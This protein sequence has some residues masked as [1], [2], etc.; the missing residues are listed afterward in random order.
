VIRLRCASVGL[1]VIGVLSI[2]AGAGAENSAGI[3]KTSKRFSVRDDIELTRF[4]W[5][6]VRASP[7]YQ[8]FAIVSERG[9]LDRN[10][11]EDSLWVFRADDILTRLRSAEQTGG[12][13]VSQTPLVKITAKHSPVIFDLD[14][15]DDSTLAFRTQTADHKFQL[16]KADVKT[17]TVEAISG[18]DQ[19]VGEFGG[20]DVRNGNAIYSVL[21][22]LIQREVEDAKKPRP[23]K[24]IEGS[25]ESVLNLP[26]SDGS[27]SHEG[28]FDWRE[29][30]AVIRG[31]RFRVDTSAFQNPLHISPGV[32]TSRM[33]LSPDGRFVVVPLPVL[34]VP[35]LWSSYAINK[36][37][38]F[39]GQFRSGSQN[40]EV[41]ETDFLAQ[42]FVM[43]DLIKGTARPLLD[44][45]IGS[46]GGYHRPRPVA[47][48]SADGQRIALVNT[49]L[50]I[51]S[52]ESPLVPCIA[53][54][55]VPTGKVGCVETLAAE[56]KDGY[57]ERFTSV[58]DLHF[59]PNDGRRLI[60]SYTDE[61]NA[62]AGK[63]TYQEEQDITWTRVENGMAS[64]SSVEVIVQESLNDPPRLVAVDRKSGRSTLV[65]DPNARVREMDLGEASEYRWADESGRSWVG[66]LVTPPDYVAGR[67]HPLVI[68]THGF[69]RNKFMGG[70]NLGW[71][72]AFAARPLAAN[73]IVVLQVN[74]Q[75]CALQYPGSPEESEC[76]KAAYESAITKL[77]HDG[78]IDSNKIGII[79]FS[80]TGLHVMKMLTSSKIHLAAATLSD[81]TV[82]GYL[83]F[84]TDNPAD[85]QLLRNDVQRIGAEPI[86]EG[87]QKWLADS[88]VFNIYKISTPT[89]FEGV[90][91]RAALFMWEPY[92]LLRY[93][94]KPTEMIQFDFGTH[95]LSNPAER[96]ASQGGNVDWFRFWLK[97]E[98]DP[99]PAKQE[100]YARW[101]ELR[102]L[103]DQV[104]R[105][106]GK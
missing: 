16:L 7:G 50:P 52:A 88:P 2:L 47:V 87:L 93:L 73:G 102:K 49:Y 105:E 98:E 10:V 101:H 26:E 40:L 44:A 27:T 15:L 79:G 70:G 75:V 80:Q 57:G 76:G 30:W 24:V 55:D 56:G 106:P 64:G 43:I 1:L 33:A 89:R 17:G 4:D 78:I 9:D 97:D 99:D 45:P 72:T 82:G 5:E 61:P 25:L 51:E 96:I 68:Q 34:S 54:L 13:G 86:G 41:R 37:Q 66:G 38:P 84:V 39:F 11:V 91:P 62:T 83:E 74:D 21:S 8:Y 100:Q 29:L 103:R 6:Q 28:D 94:G 77:V 12:L 36:G 67:R 59:D 18:P 104:S 35:D 63:L 58:R 23:A 48:W 20:F 19:D 65:L 22:P 3:G 60:F 46:R 81:S 32:L 71:G 14:W 31:R 53:V 85:R 90:G 42:Q 95:P 92:A 69:M